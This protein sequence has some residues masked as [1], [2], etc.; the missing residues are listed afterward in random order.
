MSW[1]AAFR[2][3]AGLL[4]LACASA[5]GLAACALQYAAPADDN[6]A[7]LVITADAPV[8]VLFYRDATL[9]TDA[10]QVSQP[11]P[12]TSTSYKI[13]ANEEFA[14]R[15]MYFQGWYQSWSAC[16]EEIV[17]FYVDKAKKYRLIYSLERDKGQCR[18][19]I[20]ESAGGHETPVK[21]WKRERD[22][23]ITS[24]GGEGTWCKAKGDVQPLPLQH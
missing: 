12:G 17:S 19:V 5:A 13:P 24:M 11:V 3:R 2:S 10:L 15:F 14:M 8:S 21:V 4:A 7:E 16:D 6:V 18:W 22:P 20:T 1:I 23:S 9:C